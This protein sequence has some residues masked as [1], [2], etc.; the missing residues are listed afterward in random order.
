MSKTYEE[1]LA[2]ME[3]FANGTIQLNKL[4]DSDLSNIIVSLEK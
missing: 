4:S 2:L 1:T 3:D